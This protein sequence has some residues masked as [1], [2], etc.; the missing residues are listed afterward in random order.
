MA[1]TP[2]ARPPRPPA[3]L[4]MHDENLL[5]SSGDVSP[6]GFLGAHFPKKF[7][8]TDDGSPG[9]PERTGVPHR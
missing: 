2:A 6:V 8:R 3:L 5:Q 1:V 7:L 4:V 9:R